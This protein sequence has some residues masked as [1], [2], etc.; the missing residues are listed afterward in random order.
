MEISTGVLSAVITVLPG[1][2]AADPWHGHFADLALVRGAI[3]TVLSA[4][5]SFFTYPVMWVQRSDG[6]PP[7]RA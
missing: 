2:R 4:W 1:V 6:P 7:H 5:G 3:A